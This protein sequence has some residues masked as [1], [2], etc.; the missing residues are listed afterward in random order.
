MELIC[1]LPYMELGSEIV[2]QIKELEEAWL[3]QDRK[4]DMA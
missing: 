3:Q 1:Y 4:Q 2:E